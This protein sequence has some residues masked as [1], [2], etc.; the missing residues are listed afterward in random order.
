MNI[1]DSYSS[2]AQNLVQKTYDLAKNSNHNPVHIPH[3][4]AILVNQSSEISDILQSCWVDL[5]NIKNMTQQSLVA[6][7]SADGSFSISQQLNDIFEQANSIAQ[8]RWKKQTEVYDIFLSLLK[9][10]TNINNWLKDQ[11]VTYDKVRT[12]INKKSEAFVWKEWFSETMS[13]N[14]Y[15]EDL[16]KLAE[17]WKLRE[18]IWR[19]KELR[20]IIEILWWKEKNNVMVLGESGVWKTAIVELLAQK[21]VSWDVPDFLKDKQIM[22]INLGS[23]ISWS[24]YRGE[25]EERIT[26]ILQTI[27]NSNGKIILFIDE[28]HNISWAGKTEWSMDLGEI[29]K[30]ELSSGNLQ[31]IGATTTEEYHINL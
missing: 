27:K 19:D 28:I 24:K 2:S 26:S 18:V 5:K 21:I 13:S 31:L 23:L 7:L 16:T 25:F 11:W 20:K 1:F 12:T 9:S 14:K 29:L 22:K 6:A 10:D 15:L 17:D 4:F 8:Q 3:L 30:P